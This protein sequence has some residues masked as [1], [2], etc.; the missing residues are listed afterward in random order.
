M[1]LHSTKLD[2]HKVAIR[3]LRLCTEHRIYLKNFWLKRDSMQ[4]KFCEKLSKDIDHSDYWLLDH[5]FKLSERHFGPFSVD[6][7]A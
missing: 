7:F 4:I 2:C 1:K 6:Y 5:D 3:I